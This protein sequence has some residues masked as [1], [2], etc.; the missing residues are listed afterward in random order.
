MHIDKDVV[1]GVLVV[2]LRGELDHHAVEPLRD[3]IE[4]SLE[5]TFYRGW[6]SRFRT[7]TSWTVPAS[8]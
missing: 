3:E 8:V 7:L 2:R 4:Q 5:Q 1:G 6:S